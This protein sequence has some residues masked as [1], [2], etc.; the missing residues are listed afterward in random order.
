V[1]TQRDFDP[2]ERLRAANPVPAGQLDDL[3]FGAPAQA[4]FRRIVALDASAPVRARQSRTPVA[5]VTTAPR[6]PSRRRIPKVAVVG[7]ALAVSVGVAGYALV[8]HQ[9]SKSATVACFMAADLRANTAVVDVDRRGPGAA[10]AD[11]WATG[12]FGRP[13]IPPPLRACIL[14]S[15]V[16]GVFPEDPGRDVCL[17]LGLTA[18][19]PPS[20]TT[21]GGRGPGPTNG[22]ISE[23][24]RFLMFRDAILARVIGQ[25]C[26]GPEPATALVREELGRAGL[27]GW[28]VR[29][30][31]GGFTAERPCASLSF[32]PAERTVVLVAGPPTP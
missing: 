29:T 25:P 12:A 32:L 22:P 17:D 9:P 2:L 15:G 10:C 23:D 1:T 11:F 5:P 7:A 18:A 27:G 14:E 26:I 16:V 21:T 3:V 19:A 4:L 28:T 13:A 31:E 30:G 6:P 24:D 8:G 20:P